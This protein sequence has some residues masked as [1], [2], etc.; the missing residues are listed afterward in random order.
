MM[1]HYVYTR[2]MMERYIHASALL[3][4]C[5]SG[6]LSCCVSSC[7]E[8]CLAAC[9]LACDW[10]FF[11]SF[12]SAGLS[13]CFSARLAACL[14]ACL[15]ASLPSSLPF[16]LPFSLPVSLPVRHTRWPGQHTG[17]PVA[18]LLAASVSNHL[19]SL[20]D[21]CTAAGPCVIN[22]Y[23]NYE[24]KFAFVELRTGELLVCPQNCFLDI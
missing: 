2:S 16:S 4:A 14:P 21:A 15:P 3:S 7:L 9:L 11:Q 20:T 8:A 24:R 5:L 1:K 19:Q 22:V 6:S 10:L 12:F 18:L 17:L 23:I 13:A